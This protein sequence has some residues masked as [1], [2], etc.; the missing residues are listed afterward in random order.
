MLV[1]ILKKY[2]WVINLC[3]LTGLAYLAAV[4]VNQKI[5]GMISSP[6]AA[7]SQKF[8]DDKESRPESSA[9][10]AISYYHVILTRNIFGIT[11]LSDAGL[12]GGSQEALPDSTLNIVLLGTIINHDASSV[13]II[14]N[15]DDNKVN[16]YRSG[17]VVD[18]INS[19]DVKVIEIMNCRVVIERQRTGR[20]TIKCKDLGEIAST[21]PAGPSGKRTQARGLDSESSADSPDN[22]GISKVGENEFEISREL[23]EDVLSDPTNIIQQARVIPQEDG[24]R[25]FGIRSNS[26]FWKIGIKNGDTLH[27]I[28]NVELNDVEKALSVFE[29]LRSQSNF[30]ID[31]TRAGK[32]YTYEY[33]VK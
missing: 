20:E 33:N 9:K 18:I 23:L 32:Q 10:R 28:N 29:E 11:N 21:S 24:L 4:T 8:L 27:K 3:L 26:I 25:F 14:K 15:P 12:P 19:E 16:G 30:T 1:T 22:E 6:R 31:F 2:V 17:E 5:E 13:A 7:A